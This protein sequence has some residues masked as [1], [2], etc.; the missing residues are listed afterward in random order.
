MKD[1]GSKLILPCLMV[2]T[3][4]GCALFGQPADTGA[5]RVS[6]D[7]WKLPEKPSN[8][9]KE[10]VCLVEVN[11]DRR[12]ASKVLKYPL[13]EGN[14]IN[15][16]TG[17]SFNANPGQYA[18]NLRLVDCTVSG[19]RLSYSAYQIP[20]RVRKG[21]VTN[22][23]FNGNELAETQDKGFYAAY[24]QPL[25]SF[26]GLGGE[27]TVASAPKSSKPKSSSGKKKRVF[28]EIDE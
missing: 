15:V 14:P 7:N 25:L 20:L 13:E 9:R 19:G 6:I 5:V 8:T 17:F 1:L 27:E 24:I 11:L 23:V 28:V 10:G 4:S 16:K 2:F 12:P 3:L 18:L 21:G 26:V 22:V